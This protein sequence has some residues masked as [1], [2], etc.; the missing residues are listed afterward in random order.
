MVAPVAR[1]KPACDF[2]PICGALIA[3]YSPL[4]ESILAGGLGG[5]GHYE[6][7][8]NDRHQ[9]REYRAPQA[10]WPWQRP[11]TC[12]TGG[13]NDPIFETQR[14]SLNNHAHAHIQPKVDQPI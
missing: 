5:H 4:M 7:P 10:R 8:A 3:A 13:E 12:V 14:G 6:Y 9:T 11:D 1:I 2:K